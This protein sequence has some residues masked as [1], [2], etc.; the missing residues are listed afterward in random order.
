SKTDGTMT[1]QGLFTMFKDI[2]F[3]LKFMEVEPAAFTPLLLSQKLGH[4]HTILG[5]WE[6]RIP[7]WHVG[8]AYGIKG[9]D[10]SYLNPDFKWGGLGTTSIDHFKTAGKGNLVVA[11]R[12]W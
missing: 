1:R 5:F 10:V 9:S 6:K 4:G 12:A 3:G 7:G 8:L 11:W 2:R